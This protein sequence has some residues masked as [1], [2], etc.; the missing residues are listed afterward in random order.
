MLV[1][2]DKE[3]FH[4]V[5]RRPVAGVA[6]QRLADL[7]P[8]QHARNG[9]FALYACAGVLVPDFQTDDPRERRA[10]VGH[11]WNQQTSLVAQACVEPCECLLGGRCLVGLLDKR[12]G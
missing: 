4:V 7:H 9:S 8:P 12:E 2:A 3:V 6:G 1:Q 11:R 5:L 10:P